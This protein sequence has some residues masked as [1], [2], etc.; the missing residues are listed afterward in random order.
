MPFQQL[1]IRLFTRL[2]DVIKVNVKNSSS[3]TPH[4]RISLSLRFAGFLQNLNT[5]H[6]LLYE[7]EI[8]IFFGD[9]DDAF[10]R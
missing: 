1:V 7:L 4:T 5:K 8:V 9:C 2:I 3:F 6:I 10:R